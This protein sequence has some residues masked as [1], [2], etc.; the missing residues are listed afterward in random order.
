MTILLGIHYYVGQWNFEYGLPVSKSAGILVSA[1][2]VVILFY[3]LFRKIIPKS[4]DD[5][6]VICKNCFKVFY[7][8]DI[9]NF[10]CPEC[11]GKTKKLDGF[12]ES[13]PNNKKKGT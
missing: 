9:L 6:F 13:Q 7:A 2:G 10:A 5:N 12:F 1:F 8:K 4:Y 11:G 3:G